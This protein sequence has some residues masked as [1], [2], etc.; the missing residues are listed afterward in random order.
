M[1]HINQTFKISV[2]TAFNIKYGPYKKWLTTFCAASPETQL[3][4]KNVFIYDNFY[5][6]LI[7]KT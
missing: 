5:I 7:C 2:L 6:P 4:N 3:L 1:K